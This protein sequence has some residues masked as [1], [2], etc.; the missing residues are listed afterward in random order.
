MKVQIQRSINIEKPKQTVFDIIADLKQWNT[1][2]PWMQS[3][4]TA[5]TQFSG[6]SGQ[7]G[8]TQSWEGEVIGSGRMTIVD[9]Q[10]N[11]LMKMNLEFFTPWKS[12]AE[13]IFDIKEVSAQQCKVTWTMN[14]NL[15][16]FMFAFKNMMAAYIGNDFE[17]GLK[18]LKEYAETGAVVSRSVYQGEKELPGF[19]VIGKKTTS[20]ISDLGTTIRADFDDMN[21]RLQSGE[22]TPPDGIVT[23]SHKHDIPHGTSVFTA[24]YI[25]KPNQT[26]KV[27]GD[28]EITQI[29]NHKALVVDYYGPYR[30]IGNPWSMI[31]SYQRGKK[32]KVAKSVPMYELY[33]T[34]PDGRPEKDIHTQIT[35]PIK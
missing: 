4:P 15:P 28:F 32:K 17:R 18:M 29:P 19:Q 16:W 3:E 14:S 12:F 22:L 33:K 5:K 20:K 2:S 34:M 8:Q 10:K 30:N 35:L 31:V 13:A 11:Q 7:V 26:P 27:P 9:L 23:L 1:W 24:G 25:Y 21:K 6:I